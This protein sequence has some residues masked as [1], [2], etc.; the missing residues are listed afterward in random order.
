[1]LEFVIPAFGETDFAEVI[2]NPR[3]RLTVLHNEDREAYVAYYRLFGE[4]SFSL[5]EERGTETHLFSAFKKGNTAVFLNFYSEARELYIVTEEDSRYFSY[6]DIPRD[7]SVAPQITQI[8]LEDF[9]M[10][11]VIR[12]SDGRFIVIDGGRH[13]EPD[14]DRLFSRLKSASPDETPIIAAWIFTHPHADHFYC[15]VGFV[16]R[17]GDQVKIE[18]F[19][20]NFPEAEALEY[21]PGLDFQDSRFTGNTKPTHYLGL[22]WER[23]AR[24]GAPVYTAHTGQKY[25]IGDADCE[26]L[27]SMDDSITVDDNVNAASLVIRMELAGQIILWSGDSAYSTVKLPQKHGK[28]LKAD[29]LQIPHHGF[30]SG[31]SEAE[32]AGYKLIRPHT[33]LL[34]V[35]DYNAFTVFSAF[36]PGTNY[37]MNTLPEVEEVIAGT[38]QR[39]ITLPYTPHAGAKEELKH[40]YLSGRDNCGARTWIFTELSTANEEDFLFTILN[41]TTSDVTVQIELFFEESF[42]KIR[43]IKTVVEEGTIRRVNIVGDDVNSESV[44]FNWLSLKTQGIPE[45]APFAVR[46]MSEIPVVVS[47]RNHTAAYR[48]TIQ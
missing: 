21:Y 36:R 22:M 7:I 2:E 18:K 48:S 24:I 4:K 10:S 37:L 43:Y 23:I 30:G 1:M 33:C 41:P 27:S 40:K 5:E 26:I 47:N 29:I 3:T 34:P 38:P 11:Y 15:F 16:D 6:T 8:R 28:Y 17:Y 19:L 46:F 42:R 9:G 39:T 25:R 44:Y 12:I 14:Q 32:I 13:F 20:F 31:S 45:N 35:S